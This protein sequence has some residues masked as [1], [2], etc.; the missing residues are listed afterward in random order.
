MAGAGR[1]PGLPARQ[2]GGQRR[3]SPSARVVTDEVAE[4]EVAEA[5]E[6]SVAAAEIA[7]RAVRA[8]N[9]T[10]EEQQGLP[11]PDRRGRRRRRPRHR[12][13]AG[14]DGRRRGGRRR[15]R[16]ACSPCWR[17]PARPSATRPAAPAASSGGC[18][19][20]AVGKSLGNTEPVTAERLADG[21]RAVGDRPA[22]VQ[23]GRARRQDHARRAVPVRRHP[24]ERDRGRGRLGRPGRPRRRPASSAAEA[25]A[26][27]TPKIGRARPLA[28]RSIGTPDPGAIS[29]GLIVT[30]IGD[31]LAD[32]TR[33]RKESRMNDGKKLRIVVGATTPACSTRTS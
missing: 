21:G 8:L 2:R 11:R 27:L 32:A 6:A 12:H 25:T 16:A 24:D 19:S 1:H 20:T 14:L 18:C 30:A 22:D 4:T 15:P 29:L 28:E 10:V 33:A 31:V 9:D 26:A 17:R 5:S 7:R 13:V 23:Q 3:G